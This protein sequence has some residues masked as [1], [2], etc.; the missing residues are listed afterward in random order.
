VI[1]LP[2]LFIALT[3]I[4]LMAIAANTVVVGQG[5]APAPGG[6]RGRGRL[7]PP[8]PPAVQ[9]GHPSG[10]LVIWG[11]MAD[12]TR[13]APVLRCYATSRFHRGQRAGFRMTAVDGGTGEVENSTEMVIHITHAGNTFDLPMRWR[14][15]QPYP[16]DEYIHAPVEMWTGVW[17]VPA[18]APL[19]TASYT[20]TAKDKFGR[21]ATFNPFPN[22]LS[23]L[24]IVE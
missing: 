22:H 1:S 24:A 4:T 16:A 3:A 17:E 15:N 14:G 23:Q 5:Q 11:D 10:K 13:P 12:F 7:D 19:G 20:V 8:T 9:A 21:T 18:D 2:K 6:G